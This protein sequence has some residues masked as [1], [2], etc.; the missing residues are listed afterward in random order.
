MKLEL[1]ADV[2]QYLAAPA[3]T[4]CSLEACAMRDHDVSSHR[5]PSE[6]LK[7]VKAFIVDKE[8]L[9]PLKCLLGPLSAFIFTF[10]PL[11]FAFSPQN[12]HYLGFRVHFYQEKVF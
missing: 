10:K 6:P 7:P 8:P 2:V 12:A 4:D 1:K 3:I 5:P 9:E 11:F